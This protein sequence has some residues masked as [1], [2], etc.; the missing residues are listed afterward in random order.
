MFFVLHID[1]KSCFRTD[2]AETLGIKIL[3]FFCFTWQRGVMNG[4]SCKQII[5][6]QN[7][8]TIVLIM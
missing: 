3:I 7:K 5:K 4:K 6:M 8:L 1:K 2:L